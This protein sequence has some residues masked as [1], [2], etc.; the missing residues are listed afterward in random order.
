M[1]KVMYNFTLIKLKITNH[2]KDI[3]DV[4]FFDHNIDRV[5]PLT[6]VVIG[7]NGAGKSYLLK[8]ISDIFNFLFYK[9]NSIK[10]RTP[11][12]YEYFYLEYYIYNDRY[13]IEMS[14]GKILKCLCNNNTVSIN[15]LILPSKVLAVSFMV[16]DKFIFTDNKDQINNM[17]S[18]LGV[19]KTANSTYTSSLVRLVLN[20]ILDSVRTDGRAIICEALNIMHMRNNIKISIKPETQKISKILDSGKIRTNLLQK[21]KNRPGKNKENIEIEFLVEALNNLSQYKETDINLQEPTNISYLVKYKQALDTLVDLHILAP[22]SIYFFKNDEPIS[23]EDC[24]SGEKHIIFAFTSIA[25]NIKFNSLVLIDEPEISLHPNWQIKYIDLLKITFKMYSS[26]H[27]L[28]ATHSHF[29]ISDL[30]EGSSSVVILKKD[31]DGE[32]NRAELLPYST[33][34]WSAEN[35]IYNVFGLRTVRNFYF[36]MELR[37][38]LS[39]VQNNSNDLGSIERLHTKLSNY[40]IDEKDPLSIVMQ[41]VGVYVDNVRRKIAE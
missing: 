12:R 19:R 29:L 27:F 2:D 5:K 24:S 39:L 17:Y 37:E 9:V 22:I 38:L 7:A 34:S 35:I 16:N 40:I 10:K 14:R 18:Y 6:T 26:C 30:E 41:E 13:I 25:A 8:L 11:F 20:N 31:E 3:C 15:N 21:L 33:F 28:L 36:E 4:N 32:T 23:F 1:Y